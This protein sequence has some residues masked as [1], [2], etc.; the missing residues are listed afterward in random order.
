MAN[1]YQNAEPQNFDAWIPAAA[2][3]G[4]SLSQ[5][6]FEHP[7][8]LGKMNRAAERS[9]RLVDNIN[10][11]DLS[12]EEAYDRRIKAVR[13]ATGVELDNPERHRMTERERRQLRMEGVEPNA[14]PTYQR[15]LFDDRLAILQNAHPDKA[16]KLQF[17]DINEEAKAVAK[18]AEDEYE[19][20]RRSTKLGTAASLMAQ[21]GGGFVGSLRDPLFSGS[22]LAG[23]TSAAGKNVA[24]RIFSAAWRQGAYNAGITAL[25]QPAVQAWR[26]EIGVQSGI[27]PAVENVGMSFLFGA[28]PGAVFR[29]IGEI[30]GA[31]KA[32]LKRVL[33]GNPQPGDLEK[34]MEAAQSA[35]KEIDAGIPARQTVETRAAQLGVDMDAAEM[36][37]RPPPAKDIAPELH[38]DLT[39][40]ALRHADDPSAP[41]PQAVAAVNAI[42]AA[43]PE[44]IR[45]AAYKVGD[46]VF[47]API[48]AIARDDAMA[49][50]GVAREK[51]LIDLHPGADL[52]ERLKA[53]NEAD[54][55]VTTNGRFVSRM[56]AQDI[57]KQLDQLKEG[58]KGNRLG[59]L[60]AEDLGGPEGTAADKA[61]NVEYGTPLSPEKP[62]S[63][64]MQE[65]QQRVTEAQPQSRA[66]AEIAASEAL[67]DIGNRQTNVRTR[68]EL[69]QPALPEP[70][71]PVEGVKPPPASSK[72]PLDKI[73]WTD[74]DG[75]TKLIS[76]Q[77]AARQGDRDL[78]IIDIIREC[79]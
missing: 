78:S 33:D 48:H 68:E 61:L 23:P 41:T 10:S 60:N 74:E 43:E 55:F 79:K 58:K 64:T 32:P 73:P 29:G 4:L 36:A 30:P 28:I 49:A 76:A 57:A 53:S 42:E 46:R 67:E 37:T 20:A 34:A 16:E 59:G 39:N 24:A 21:F 66:E 15:K 77:N 35:L 40:A 62:L 51:D 7:E 47:E 1:L 44:R 3:D 8:E 38:D 5:A 52:R 45:A 22:M 54:G 17:G 27:T 6:I 69:T 25:E 56:E 18:D 70:P 50:L 26:N 11:H 14:I 12:V 13:E 71:P 72:D 31:L 65:V 75:N 63:P 19:Q 9:Q 2:D